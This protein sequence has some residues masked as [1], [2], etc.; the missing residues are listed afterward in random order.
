MQINVRPCGCQ[1]GFP[2][3]TG[4]VQSTL[5]SVKLCL[6]LSEVNCFHALW[7]EILLQSLNVCYASKKCLHFIQ[8]SHAFMFFEVMMC[9]YYWYLVICLKQTGTLL[10]KWIPVF[11]IVICVTV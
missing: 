1:V 8:N 3:G 10:W 6:S 2:Y 5:S 4:I 7:N 11:V 9:Y